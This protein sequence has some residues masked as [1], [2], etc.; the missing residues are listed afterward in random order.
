MV[1]LAKEGKIE[2]YAADKRLSHTFMI[3]SDIE[4]ANI[5]E[6]YAPGEKPG[7]AKRICNQWIEYAPYENLFFLA[8]LWKYPVTKDFTDHFLF[9]TDGEIR[10]L[11]KWAAKKRKDDINIDLETCRE[12]WDEYLSGQV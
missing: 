5:E 3:F 10:E 11:R 9:L 7:A 8:T 12:F 4:A 6:P 2:L 1:R